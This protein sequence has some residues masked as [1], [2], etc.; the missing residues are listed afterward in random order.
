MRGEPFREQPHT[1]AQGR[2]GEERAVEWLR[3]E[4]YRIVER[5]VTT[6]AG[7]IDVVARDGET[8]CFIEV[9]ARSSGVY[10]P[11]VEAVTVKKMRKLARAASLYL[12]RHPTDAPC[13]FDV[14]GM[15]LDDGGWRFTLV[16]DA[17]S[18]PG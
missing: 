13:R 15:D 12:V 5:N 4:G 8:L 7:E 2:V 16:R 3:R 9:K 14:L 11:A 6:K 18:V 10:G 1:R 17:F